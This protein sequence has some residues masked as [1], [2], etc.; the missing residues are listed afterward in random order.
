MTC[1][2]SDLRFWTMAQTND[3]GWQLQSALGRFGEHRNACDFSSFVEL[4]GGKVLT[5]SHWGA[6]LVWHNN[7]VQVS[8]SV[9]VLRAIRSNRCHALV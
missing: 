1:G 3:A 2:A 8:V 7:L 9:S 5:G 6:L 4:P